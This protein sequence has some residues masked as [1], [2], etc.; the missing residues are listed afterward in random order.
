MKKHCQYRE[1]KKTSKRKKEQ[2][3]FFTT[4]D[5]HVNEAREVVYNTEP[6]TQGRWYRSAGYI[7]ARWLGYDD[8]S[9]GSRKANWRSGATATEQITTTLIID[10]L[11]HCFLARHAILLQ[12]VFR[13]R[14]EEGR[15]GKGCGAY[16]A[17]LTTYWALV[18]LISLSLTDRRIV[19]DSFFTSLWV[20]QISGLIVPRLWFT[21][22]FHV[23]GCLESQFLIFNN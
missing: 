8:R 9:P 12:E 11:W 15:R 6:N 5:G 14:R 17:L 10:E 20:F 7:G 2:W 22:S 4:P 13:R 21:C 18:M 1:K 19:K 16:G 3:F 23:A